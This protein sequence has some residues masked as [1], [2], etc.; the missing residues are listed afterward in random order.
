MKTEKRKTLSELTDEVME[1][2]RRERLTAASAWD[3]ITAVRKRVH[4]SAYSK[5]ID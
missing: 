5:T 1:I 4:E 3:V 2:F